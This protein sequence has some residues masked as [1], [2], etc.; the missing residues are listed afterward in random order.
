VLEGDGLTLAGENLGERLLLADGSYLAAVRGAPAGYVAGCAL[1]ALAPGDLISEH[2]IASFCFAAFVLCITDRTD[3]ALHALNHAIGQARERGSKLIFLLA[4]WMR[5]HVHYRRGELDAAEADASS[6]LDAGVDDWF[7]AP[8]AFLADVMIERGE[9]QAA[10]ALFTRY[11]PVDA[12]FPNLLVANFVLDSRGR[13][14]CAEGR[15]REG[16]ED[17]LAVGERLRAWDE[18]NPAMISWRSSAA[19]AYAALG[20]HEAASRLSGQEVM[21]A[22]SF[23][24]PRALGVALRAEGLLHKAPASFELF[25][26]AVTELESSPARLDL[27]RACTELGAALR[28]GGRRADAREVLRRGLDLA[29]R[30]GATVLAV[31]AREELIAAGARPRREQIRGVSALTASERRIA[32]LAAGGMSNREIAQTLFITIRTVKAHLGHI[33]QKL[34]ITSR[35]QLGDALAADKAGP[36]ANVALGSAG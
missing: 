31:R 24:A 17:L 2:T 26:E 13:L 32:T 22:R 28:R 12:V 35:G 33:F 16:L 9:L 5:S 6:A 23:G 21:L 4:S 11:G 8:V 14:R 27:A 34:D 25:G 1:R 10:E 36:D 15:W 30:C 19:L 18:A 3:D 20:N 29:S 7:T